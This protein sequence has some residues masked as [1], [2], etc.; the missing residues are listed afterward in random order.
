MTL[1]TACVVIG[2]L[3]MLN[4]IAMMGSKPSLVYTIDFVC[5]TMLVLGIFK[6]N[7]H[8]LWPMIIWYSMVTI[9]MAILLCLGTLITTALLQFDQ[10][11]I[12][13][14]G[15]DILERNLNVQG[16][17]VAMSIAIP[18][19]IVLITVGAFISLVLYSLNVEMREQ[20]NRP[21]PSASVRYTV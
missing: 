7:R 8:F 18:V 16:L 5:S 14:S 10:I 20:E 9:A 1:R 12:K 4:W 21:H 11:I 15:Q 19:L 2:A 17:N 13:L 3:D 6:N